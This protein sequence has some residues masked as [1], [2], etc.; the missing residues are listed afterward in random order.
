M[1]S[2]L[3]LLELSYNVEENSQIGELRDKQNGQEMNKSSRNLELERTRENRQVERN[4]KG[5]NFMSS[6]G[7]FERKKNVTSQQQQRAQQVSRC[8]K[9][10]K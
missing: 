2:N 8:R 3:Q 10:E 5:Q 6:I 7:Q 9:K 1:K 4:P